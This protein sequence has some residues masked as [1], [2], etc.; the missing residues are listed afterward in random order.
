[1]KCFRY[2]SAFL[3][4]L[5]IFFVKANSAVP[6]CELEAQTP[7]P[8]EHIDTLN[9]AIVR[10]QKEKMA[11]RS[12]TSLQKLDERKLK[13]GYA[14][15]GSPDLVRTLQMLPGVGSGT[16]LTSGL[17]VRGGD[18]SD[19]LFLLDGVPL[20][21]VSHLIGLFSSF[22]TDIM[23]EVD[24]YKGGFPARYGG[25]LSS[26]VDVGVKEGSFSKWKGTAALG[27]IDGRF[28]IEGPI[29]PG[30]TSLNFGVR[31][32]WLDVAMFAASPIF[33]NALKSM[34]DEDILLSNYYD[35]SDYNLKITHLIDP[36][37]RLTFSAYYGHDWARMRVKLNNMG[38]E[39]IGDKTY[40]KGKMKWGNTM[41]VLKWNKEWQND[42]MTESKIYYTNYNSDSGMGMEYSADQESMDLNERNFSR[43]H[44]IGI[45]SDWYY[46][47]LDIHRVRT[48]ASAIYHIYDPH[49]DFN[50][51]LT[52]DGTMLPFQYGSK[53]N[54]HGAE[55]AIYGEDEINFNDWLTVNL[56]LR[57]ALYV[58][59]GKAY[60]SFEPRLAIKAEVGA[61]V[62]LKA[63][64]AR[65]GQ[66]SHIVSSTYID[67]PTNLWM[68]STAT[69]KPMQAGQFV[70]GASYKPSKH[71]T[72]DIESFYKNMQHLYEYN[73][74]STL[75]PNLSTWEQDFVEG[76]GRSYG[77][78]ASLEYSDT[79]FFGAIYYTLSRS[80]RLFPS[81]YYSWF[82]DRNDNL[83]R[84][85]INANY[86]FNARFEL[87]ASWTYHTGN[88]FT[89]PSAMIKSAD[90]GRIEYIYD[91]PNS[92]HLPDY[93]RLD[94]GL[95]WTKRL[96]N[97][98]IRVVTLSVYNAY[99][100]LNAIFGTVDVR[101]SFNG[102]KII[103]T[104]M[105]LIPIIPTFSYAWKF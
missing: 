94:L 4:S 41:A 45:S 1:M 68:P 91:M 17:Y 92:Y 46:E 104:A 48:G 14:L 20:Y 42:W 44:D 74:S 31:R 57:D 61:G 77:V 55:I 16:E 7:P 29:I 102:T 100:R 28:Q 21:Q 2:I 38:M 73:A 63:S 56:G 90:G 72:F 24:F 60:N 88:R 8:S 53:L 64:Y 58:V 27:I 43:I 26:V 10:T 89:A 32:T 76:K 25:R 54:Y 36:T 97:G 78:E 96:K 87:Y 99:N 49:R 47:S 19:N 105:G 50:L 71:W 13:R 52:Y 82:P 98:T 37:S 95:N 80:E 79:H 86:R 35:F 103:G 34:T 85:N 81:Y 67:L 15:L 83:H 9:A 23:D 59:K 101:D 51:N 12:Q 40:M 62:S 65:M 3:C 84:L 11:S 5:I 22:N 93:H 33:N 18:G 30:R 70:L 66:F 69:V 75:L 6:L 39:D